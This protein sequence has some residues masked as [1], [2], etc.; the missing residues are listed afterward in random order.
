[1]PKILAHH[2]R[3]VLQIMISQPPDS[4]NDSLSFLIGGALGLLI[5]LGIS[6]YLA[7]PSALIYATAVTLAITLMSTGVGLTLGAVVVVVKRLKAE[8]R[9][10]A[11]KPL[12]K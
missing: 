5:G 9:A 3:S 4:Q 1:M 7:G 6:H 2:P 11:R 8:K 12:E 10:A